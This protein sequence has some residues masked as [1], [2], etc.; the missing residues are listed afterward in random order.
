[1]ESLSSLARVSGAVDGVELVL[2]LPGLLVALRPIGV[3]EFARFLVPGAPKEAG[4]GDPAH[5]TLEEAR[6]Y[7]RWAG[8]RLFLPHEFTRL[9]KTA[10]GRELLREE[11]WEWVD[12]S[13]GDDHV[14]MTLS[15]DASQGYAAKL[16]GPNRREDV[17]F[18]WVREA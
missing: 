18:R 3:R 4:P 11:R 5:P 2:A 7:A 9:A 15:L 17:A 16:V 14:A 6:A 13:L 1:M 12:R 10:L 8:G